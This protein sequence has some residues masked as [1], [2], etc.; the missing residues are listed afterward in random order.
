MAGRIHGKGMEHAERCCGSQLRGRGGR[1]RRLESC[2]RTLRAA[3]GGGHVVPWLLALPFL[4]NT[5][6]TLNVP[7]LVACALVVVRVL[8]CYVAFFMR[9]GVRRPD[10]TVKAYW[11]AQEE[12]EEPTEETEESREAE[13]EP[14]GTSADGTSAKQSEATREPEAKR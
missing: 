9:F 14:A 11:E 10:E 8:A 3:P 4:G 6:A 7:L 12:A 13:R 2:G 5:I 1:S